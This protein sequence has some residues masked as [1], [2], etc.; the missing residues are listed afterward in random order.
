MLSI[1]LCIMQNGAWTYAAMNTATTLHFSFGFLSASWIKSSVIR[2]TWPRQSVVPRP[3]NLSPSTVSLNGSRS[4]VSGLAGT[5]SRWLPI[6][7]TVSFGSPYWEKFI[8]LR[9]RL[10]YYDTDLQSWFFYMHINLLNM[11]LYS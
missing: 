8:Y 2:A 11:G 7:D 10:Y 1:M 9:L 4:Q 6:N 5:T 3:C